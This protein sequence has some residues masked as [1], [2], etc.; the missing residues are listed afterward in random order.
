ML[1]VVW[2]CI[3]GLVAGLVAKL[4]VPGKDPGG[5]ILTLALGLMG[6]FAGTWV[7]RAFGHDQGTAFL[8]SVAGAAILLGAHHLIMRTRL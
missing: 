5:W 6:S 2:T 3:I 1:R 4:L 7:G 8:L